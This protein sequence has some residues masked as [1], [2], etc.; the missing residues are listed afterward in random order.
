MSYSKVGIGNVNIWDETFN[1]RGGYMSIRVFCFIFV[2]FCLPSFLS[3][4]GRDIGIPATSL[5]E[6]VLQLAPNLKVKMVIFSLG[7]SGF[8][9]VSKKYIFSVLPA[10][11]QIEAYNKLNDSLKMIYDKE[12][13]ILFCWDKK[14]GNEPDSYLKNKHVPENIYNPNKIYRTVDGHVL[15]K[16]PGD[17]GTYVI[18]EFKRKIGIGVGR[19]V[20][21]AAKD[22]SLLDVIKDTFKKYPKFNICEI[23]GLEKTAV[24][25]SDDEMP[26]LFG[27]FLILAPLAI[28]ENNLTLDKILKFH[29]DNKN[30]LFSDSTS[31][32]HDQNYL[33]KY[34][35]T[36]Y[37]D[38]LTKV[39]DEGNFWEKYASDL[40]IGFDMAK[41]IFSQK[42]PESA[43]YY[44]KILPCFE[45]TPDLGK[46]SEFF[47]SMDEYN[48]KFR[49]K[50]KEMISRDDALNFV[51][52]MRHWDPDKAVWIGDD[53]PDGDDCWKDFTVPE[54]E[55][56]KKE[57]IKINEIR[58]KHADDF[59]RKM[60]IDSK[61]EIDRGEA[62]LE[63][64]KYKTPLIISG[65]PLKSI[66]DT[67][68]NSMS[69]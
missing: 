31:L 52:N 9:T 4:A 24:N 40:D 18:P 58:E 17:T 44:L 13:N 49:D 56:V 6:S 59:A 22:A 35:V 45:K 39:L 63:Y 43:E 66:K 30:V 36:F 34:C 65:L 37:F 41:T 23:S 64:Y 68:S 47:P 46:Y 29:D 61:E 5:V 10:K 60:M 20:I 1:V 50:I 54:K 16:P 8:T 14:L 2:L 12:N 32:S 55:L 11:E 25:M 21:I 3:Q 57:T 26:R 62:T 19:R 7:K 38:K 53:R 51:Y 48:G 28:E 69:N 33:D 15:N 67:D 42:T 27:S